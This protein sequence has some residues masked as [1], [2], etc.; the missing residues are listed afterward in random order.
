MLKP[1]PPKPARA[2]GAAREFSVFALVVLVEAVLA[3][4]F[5]LIDTPTLFATLAGV[6]VLALGGLVASAI[7]FGDIWRRGAPGFGRAAVA[8]VAAVL[9]LTPFAGVALAVGVY[10]ELTE[11]STDRTSPPPFLTDPSRKAAGALDPAEAARLQADAYP[12]L[13]GRRLPLSTVEA[14]G[15]VHLT[16]TELGWVIVAE[17]EPATEA[18]AGF[19]E[20]EAR[21]L[22]LGIP[23][24]VAIRVWPDAG[25]SR[26]DI[27]SAS[28]MAVHDLGENARHV[29]TFLATI[30]EILTRPAD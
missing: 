14:Q 15:L 5:D 24:D 29:R 30:D 13:V 9:A 7:A 12:D 25:G 22:T 28:R 6:L 19:L 4:R 27:R 11:V 20:A 17:Q 16:A 1:L 8:F 10:P 23:D 3:R 21:S 18:D 2:A 26:I